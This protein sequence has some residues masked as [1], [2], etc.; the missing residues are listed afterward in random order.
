M[1][2]VFVLCEIWTD[3]YPYSDEYQFSETE[4]FS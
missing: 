2:A 1:D 3:F 4:E